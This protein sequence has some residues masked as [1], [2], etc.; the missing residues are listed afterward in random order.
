MTR[1]ALLLA[2]TLAGALAC[3]S[4]GGAGIAE[5]RDAQGHRLASAGG[6]AFAS[7]QDSGW[8][9]RFDSASRSVRGVS[10]SGVSMAGGLV[11]ADRVFVPAHGL[12]GARVVGLTVNGRAVGALP[13]TLVP[14]GPSSYLV[15]LQEAVVPGEGSGIVG[16][17][18]VAGDASLGL[19]PGTQI[20]VGL[21][22]AAMPPSPHRDTRLAWLALGVAGHGVDI[23]FGDHAFP[24]QFLLGGFPHGGTPGDRAVAIAEQYLGIPYRWGGADPIG[25]FDCSGLTMYVYAQLGI[26]LTHYTGSQFY[27]GMRIPP[28]R[29]LPGDLLF[30][31]PSA[32]GP[33]H[34]GMYIGGGRF[35]HAPH[36]GDVVKISSLAEPGYAFSFVGAVRPWAG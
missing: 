20:L 26:Q 6:G 35:I 28:S 22:R 32:R 24:E 1:R 16:L 14:L 18:L 9:L 27:E 17:R 10:L 12:R 23:G 4:P 19:D 13:N 2:L 8:T 15:V 36:T 34:E 29:L 25:G 11:Y 21:A 7:V 31:H 3:C 33:Q 5:I 30:F